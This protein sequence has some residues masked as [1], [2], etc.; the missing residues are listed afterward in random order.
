M[1]TPKAFSKHNNKEE[2]E[3][4]DLKEQEDS[5]LVFCNNR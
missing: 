2:I 4:V 3:I 5:S 1:V